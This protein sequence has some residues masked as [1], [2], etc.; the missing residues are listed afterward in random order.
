MAVSTVSPVKD[1]E[2]TL[3]A[4]SVLACMLT[5]MLHE[6]VGHAAV[7]MVTLHASGVL[8]TLA[9]SSEGAS[10]LV[11]AGGTL[12]NLLT[13]GVVWLLL[14]QA[15]EASAAWR[16]FL[17]AVM[18]FSL[19]AGTGYFFYSGVTDFGDWAAVIAGLTPHWLWRAGLVIVGIAAYY[20]AMQIVGRTVVW[21]LGVAPVESA[22]F[23][24]LMVVTY[25]A[26]L[27]IDG[28][29]GLFNPFGLKYV[30]LSALAA[31]AGANSALLWMRKH[32]PE[33]L[34]AGPHRDPV[35][36]S[37]AWIA[38]A[39]VLAIVFI[40]VLGPGVKLGH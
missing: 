35:R 9:W 14:R 16:Y 36:R 4:I 8:T 28:V 34:E 3:A 40:A 23:Q 29:A 10:R 31:T 18:T 33:G 32:L 24:R 6:G 13:A 1:D 11:E 17:W 22:R 39:A 27:A 5:T 12:V 20:A 25:I 15:K 30:L 38:V 26:A 2:A 37:A 7:A 21:S 19:F